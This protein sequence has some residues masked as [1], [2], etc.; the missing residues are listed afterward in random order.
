MPWIVLRI[1]GREVQEISLFRMTGG[2]AMVFVFFFSHRRYWAMVE[3]TDSGDGCYIVIAGETN[4]NFLGF[5]DRYNRLE[6]SIK[7]E[8][9]FIEKDR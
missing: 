4:R 7:E 6:S 2:T 3:P 1:P 9:G 8:L 5:K